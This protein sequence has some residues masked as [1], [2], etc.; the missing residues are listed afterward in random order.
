MKDHQ[1][2][3]S[4][5]VVEK[6]VGLSTMEQLLKGIEELKIKIVK[7]VK[8]PVGPGY[9]DQW[10][11]WSDRAKHGLRDCEELK[12]ALRHD[13][14]YYKDGWIH[15]MDSSKSVRPNFRNVHA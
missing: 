9:K 2:Q 5:T 1:P 13:M 6:S 7:M 14:F 4:E 12:E 3:Y 8:R 10:C 15:S 11:I